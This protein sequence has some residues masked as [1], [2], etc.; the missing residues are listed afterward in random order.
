LIALCRPGMALRPD[1]F[2][3]LDAL[4]DKPVPHFT[5]NLG[6]TVVALRQD[7]VLSA[8]KVF[9]DG[10]GPLHLWNIERTGAKAKRPFSAEAV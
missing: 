4:L 8:T 7:G 2:G 3:H 5:P 6:G 10:V 1:P 9:G